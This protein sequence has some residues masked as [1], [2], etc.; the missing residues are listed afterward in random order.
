[1]TE[2]RINL[3]KIDIVTALFNTEEYDGIEARLK[4]TS[5]PLNIIPRRFQ[6]EPMRYTWC[7]DAIVQDRLIRQ[8]LEA[9]GASESNAIMYFGYFKALE[10]TYG[11]LKRYAATV[12]K[13]SKLKLITALKFECFTKD[14]KTKFFDAKEEC[15]DKFDYKN[16]EELE[17]A[18]VAHTSL[19]SKEYDDNLKA[20]LE[21]LIPLNIP[22]GLHGK[23]TPLEACDFIIA[24]RQGFK[25]PMSEDDIFNRREVK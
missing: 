22:A 23:D 5:T 10:M 15:T 17:Q 13:L 20:T 2:C 8:T 11:E 6:F 7:E 24:P 12:T 21:V 1:M 3:K 19:S 16:I 9:C 4:D 25:L 14:G 18:R